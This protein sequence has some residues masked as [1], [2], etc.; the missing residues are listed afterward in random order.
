[1]IAVNYCCGNGKAFADRQRI[2]IGGRKAARVCRKTQ[3]LEEEKE[4]KRR[5]IEEEKEEKRRKLAE[6]RRK[7]EEEKEERRRREDE[8]R[9]AWRQE[10]DLRKLELV[11][12]LLKQKEAIEAAKREHEL[13]LARLGQ[14]V[15]LPSTL[16]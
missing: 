6:E 15:T 12:E 2:R 4:E 13:E 7:E 14:G 16:K 11:A 1:M 9:E 3:K 10:H 8:E 5:Q